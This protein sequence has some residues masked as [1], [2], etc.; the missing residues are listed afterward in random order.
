MLCSRAVLRVL[1]C[2]AV[3]HAVCAV[4]SCRNVVVYN[5]VVWGHA[6]LLVVLPSAVLLSAVL[7]ARAYAPPAGSQALCKQESN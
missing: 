4:L 3:G 5:V 2:F 6:V 1:S 7:H